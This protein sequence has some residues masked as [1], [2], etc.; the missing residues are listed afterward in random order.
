MKK[1]I[2]LFLVL[3]ILTITHSRA[4]LLPTKELPL[5]LFYL[6]ESIQLSPIK[7]IV[8]SDFENKL[9]YLDQ[10]FQKVEKK[11]QL[12]AIVKAEIYKTI[13]ET[14]N[15]EIKEWVVFNP[16]QIE[17]INDRIKSI[18]KPF[19]FHKWL[20]ESVLTDY[21]SLIK[22]PLFLG[23]NNKE[24]NRD[25]LIYRKKLV[26]ISNILNELSTQNFESFDN[27]VFLIMDKALLNLTST[28]QI[29]V[30][31]SF[32]KNPGQSVNM[33]YFYKSNN[34]QNQNNPLL[35]DLL[36]TDLNIPKE[37][38]DLVTA[39][40]WMP[41]KD[42]QFIVSQSMQNNEN[43]SLLEQES[44]KPIPFYSPDPNFIP[45]TPPVPTNDWEIPR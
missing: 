33:V 43:S 27:I 8:K 15:K 40:D 21:Q 11:G 10:L 29:I 17:S 14:Q 16:S 26:L 45:F 39:P 12:Y 5:E 35:K 20:L 38:E 22:S 4:T 3:F 6:T 23:L 19:R 24:I 13:L 37:N 34:F 25:V 2:K 9:M 28:L 36:N 32:D 41:K 18:S 31:H 7:N 44:I 1:N 30:N 42:D